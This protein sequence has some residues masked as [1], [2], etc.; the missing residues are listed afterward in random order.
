[1]AAFNSSAGVKWR[2]LSQPAGSYHGVCENGGGVKMWRN[3]S[4]LGVAM[5]TYQLNLAKMK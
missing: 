5:A 2:W 3:G 1:M 4:N